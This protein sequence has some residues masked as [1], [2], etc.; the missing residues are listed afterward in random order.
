MTLEDWIAI[1]NDVDG[2]GGGGGSVSKTK[3]RIA[4]GTATA[5]Q[6]IHGVQGTTTDIQYDL[7]TN[8]ATFLQSFVNGDAVFQLAAGE[9]DIHF[10]VDL[11]DQAADLQNRH[12]Y[13]IQL[14]HTNSADVVIDTYNFTSVYIRDDANA[15]DSAVLSI[16]QI[17]I[18]TSLNDKIICR[19]T[20]KDTQDATGTQPVGTSLSRVKI[21]R[22]TY[23]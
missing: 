17:N 23:S 5:S 12:I 13:D 15:Y 3:T 20:V 1:W 2:G 11:P 21:D 7:T 6:N 4:D 10:S 14:I 8:N 9:Y 19:T 16:P 18:I 22:I